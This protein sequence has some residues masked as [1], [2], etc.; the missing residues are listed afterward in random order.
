MQGCFAGQA[1]IVG[2]A[3]KPVLSTREGNVSRGGAVILRKGVSTVR[4]RYPFNRCKCCGWW[5]KSERRDIGLCSRCEKVFSG[6]FEL[7]WIRS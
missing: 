1:R 7:I 4:S 6:Q 5:L 3:G 2:L